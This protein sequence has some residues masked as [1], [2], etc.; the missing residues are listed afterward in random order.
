M[1]SSLTRC[2]RCGLPETYP[3]IKFNREGNCN[4]CVYHDLSK[5]R[6][7]IIKSELKGQFR[8]LIKKI[9]RQN[10]KYDCIVAYSGGKDS[11]FLLQFLKNEFGLKIL[12][13]TLDNGFISRAALKNIKSITS[14]LNIDYKIT[15]PQWGVLK[16]VFTQAL[17]NKFPYPKEILALASPVCAVC[18]GMVFGSTINLAMESKIPLMFIGFT[19]GQYP[20]IS[21]ENFLKVQSCMFLSDKVYRDD[22]LDIL[23]VLADPVK[24]QFGHQVEKYYFSSQYF[25]TGLPVPKVLFPF[26]VIVDYDEKQILRE[27]AKI[28]WV[29]PKDTDSCSTNCLLNTA[30][31]YACVK[32]LRY[33]PYI[34]EL[35]HSVREGKISRRQALE[36]ARTKTD[37]YALKRS[38]RALG[39]S[40]NE[41]IRQNE[42]YP[43]RK[44]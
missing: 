8:K 43:K 41:I 24:E 17:L 12:A 10:H 22:P 18:I 29:K 9:K 2:K 42:K 37:S 5:E 35:A 11:T 28:G 7:R 20:T 25:S 13:H 16:K 27:I 14:V 44:K 36:T 21:L 6:E 4:Y 31:N 40:K 32:Q 19:P 33:H 23:K 34:G 15:R 38:L 26:H 1:L 3:G 30:G 39:L